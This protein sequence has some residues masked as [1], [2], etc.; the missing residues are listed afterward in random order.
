MGKVWFAYRF[1]QSAGGPLFDLGCLQGC[2][3]K[4]H[5]TCRATVCGD[6][7]WIREHSK[8]ALFALRARNHKLNVTFNLVGLNLLL[9]FHFFHADLLH[10]FLVRLTIC[11]I[12]Y[13]SCHCLTGTWALQKWEMMFSSPLRSWRRDGV[14]H[15]LQWTSPTRPQGR[16]LHKEDTPNI[17]E[18]AETSPICACM[19]CQSKSEDVKQPLSAFT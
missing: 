8:V 1:T 4:I 16:S 17:S 2:V 6:S 10:A 13:K 9:Y 5:Q 12:N 15:L 18:A 7:L 11:L 19:Y 14:W 3:R